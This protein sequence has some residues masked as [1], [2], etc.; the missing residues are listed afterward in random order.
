MPNWNS[1]SVTIWAPINAVK[2][3]L[4]PLDKDA[5]TFNLAKLFPE[6]VR[7]DDPSGDNLVEIT[8]LTGSKRNVMIEYCDGDEDMTS[9]GYDSPRSPNN[10]TLIRLHELTGWTIENEYEEP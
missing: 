2:S 10:G 3:R 4:L 5:C 6:H 9:L 7:A 8:E 1:N